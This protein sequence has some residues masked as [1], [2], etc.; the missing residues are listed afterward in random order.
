MAVPYF[1]GRLSGQEAYK[2]GLILLT[3]V[4]LFPTLLPE[5]FGWLTSFVPLPI[6]YYFVILGKKDGTNLI[7]NAVLLAAAGALLTGSLQVLIFSLVMAP[8]GIIFSN[9]VFNRRDPVETAFIGSLIMAL[10]WILFW[11]VVG[12]IHQTNPY[13]DLLLQLDEG[14]AAGLKLY[15]ESAEL[16]PEALRSVRTAVE[17]LR[18]YI[19]KVLPALLMSAVIT[20]TWMNLV[21]GN[22]LLKKKDK[23]LTVWSDYIEWKLPESLVWLV[24]S[25]GIMVFLLPTPIDSIGL[26]IL[27]VCITVYFFQ[28]LA[29]VAS[30]LNKWSVPMFIRVL[31]YAL[32][33]I[34]T[35]G[36]IIL[37]FL[38]LA[39][40]WADFRKLNQSGENPHHSI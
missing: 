40:V 11:S 22:W 34:Q 21:L 38:G 16:K 18:N 17:L 29:I 14:L 9:A 13:A 26:N 3:A 23:E 28:G 15:E 12:F 7:R 5:K 20:I 37:S 8:L 39:D 19:P 25:A 6:F 33:F 32:I 1:K 2:T 24:I 4:L 10:T 30:L 35:Y 36:I 31:I 27:I